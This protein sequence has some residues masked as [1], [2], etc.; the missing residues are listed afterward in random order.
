MTN[1][2]GILTLTATAIYAILTYYILKASRD[3]L[4]TIF[5]PYITITHRLTRK[6]LIRLY[7]KNT[8]KTNAEDLELQI[9]RN[10][11]QLTGKEYNIAEHYAFKNPIDTFPPEAQLVFSLMS[12]AQLPANS[13]DKNTQSPIFSITAKYSYSGKTVT[14]KTTI[15]LKPYMSTFMPDASIEDRLEDLTKEISE[16]K[17]I[18]SKLAG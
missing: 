6:T 3:Q 8:G 1:S 2:I 15:D 14:E 10:F 16:I 5:R 12:T 13:F 18:V 9:D 4:D 11:Y 17:E 7:I